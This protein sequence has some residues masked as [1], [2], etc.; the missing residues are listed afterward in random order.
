MTPVR[1]RGALSRFTGLGVAVLTLSA[2]IAGSVPATAA[3]VPTTWPFGLR[4]TPGPSGQPRPYINLTMAPGGSA[5][6][7]V[8]VS[9]ESSRTERLLV[10]V[11]RGVTAANSGSAFEDIT[12]ACAGASCWLAP[13]RVRVTL[14]AGAQRI[15]RLSVAVP[16]RTR[17]GQYLA[18]I[19]ATP[20]AR[21][22]AVR[23]GSAGHSARAIIID[24]VT[25]GV[26]I[27]VGRLSRLR[28]GLAISAATAQWIGAT[29]RLQIPVRNV[30]RTFLRATGHVSCRPD[31]RLRPYRVIMETVLPGG[32]AVLQ[33]NAPG[34]RSGP[35]LCTVRMSE[36]GH[37]T[38]LWT[39]VVNV[40]TRF[41]TRTYHLAR[42]VY[43]SL[44]E[45][46]V[47]SWAIALMVIGSLLVLGVFALIVRRRPAA[48][49]QRRHSRHRQV[50]RARRSTR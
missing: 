47:P 11:S 44:P 48:S 38:A 23:I 3:G 30:G 50:V 39:G 33:V 28:R 22:P 15:L 45:P 42:G 36:A 34:L 17:P 9:N 37:R 16:R 19:T 14:A 24:E 5:T 27:T 26:A 35:A 49:L 20:A 2:A 21:P 13:R 7:A 4:P 18:G 43:V 41:A 10:M 8:I 46:V 32:H 6:D 12:G 29:P 1:A 25:V 40:P 31:R